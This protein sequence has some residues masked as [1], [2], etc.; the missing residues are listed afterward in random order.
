MI[1]KT[2]QKFFILSLCTLAPFSCSENIIEDEGDKNEAKD[3]VSISTA[4]ELFNFAER[5]KNGETILDAELVA[6]IDLTGKLWTPIASDYDK[7]YEGYFKGNKH[8]I[9]GL[10]IT[11]EHIK[12]EFELTEE[13]LMYFAHPL[14]L[15][16]YVGNDGAVTG[17]SLKDLSIETP[18]IHSV[19]G[20][21]GENDGTITTC[22]VSGK[23]V[24]KERIGGIAGAT[25]NAISGCENSANINGNDCIGGIAGVAMGYIMSCKNYG[26]IE[27]TNYVGG[28][29][30]MC[31]TKAILFNL[32][33]YGEINA[34]SV[35]GGITG[36]LAGK[37]YNNVNYGTITGTSDIGG[38]AGSMDRG[39]Y[40]ELQ[41]SYDNPDNAYMENCVNF[42]IVRGNE[43]THAAIGGIHDKTPFGSWTGIL[44]TKN[45][46]YDANAN[47][48]LTGERGTAINSN[49]L[50]TLNQWVDNKPAE[51]KNVAFKIWE[52]DE[53]G[54]FVIKKN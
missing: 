44:N 3:I 52:M 33:N 26:N 5:V 6:D 51:H 23:I 20:I 1:R 11:E 39:Y 10:T 48:S 36:L 4:D 35:A 12:N 29:S 37:F 32:E 34:Q 45:I 14:G 25:H 19:G 7:R 13:D 9:T 18:N 40:T 54:K 46:F 22:T 30:G 17:V 49:T 8:V 24:A 31:G 53:N 21:A 28:I 2:I 15:F 38:L 42:G 43:D 47:P 16:S 41:F 27:C 50:S